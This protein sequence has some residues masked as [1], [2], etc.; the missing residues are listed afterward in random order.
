M[1]I[2]IV[3]LPTNGMVIFN[4]YVSLPEGVYIYI[5]GYIYI[6]I[7]VGV[8]IYIYGKPI[9]QN[10]RNIEISLWRQRHRLPNVLIFKARSLRYASLGGSSAVLVMGIILGMK[11]MW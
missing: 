2:E 8:Y 4:N 10:A 6:N 7:S 11:K 3:D 1:T 5:C 9:Y